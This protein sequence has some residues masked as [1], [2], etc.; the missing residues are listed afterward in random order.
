[1]TNLK[2][3]DTL[4]VQAANA[5]T[6]LAIEM[7]DGLNIIA[8]MSAGSSIT[9]TTGTTGGTISFRDPDFPTGT[10]KSAD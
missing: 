8:N 4:T 5:P 9:I 6:K 7:D 3:G 2:Q 1:M 10:L